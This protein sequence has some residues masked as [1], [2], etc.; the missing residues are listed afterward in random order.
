MQMQIRSHCD[1]PAQEMCD[2]IT[3]K[4]EHW[5]HSFDANVCWMKANHLPQDA[6]WLLY[7][8]KTLAAYL[9]I[10]AV[11]ATVETGVCIPVWGIG[12]VCV[13]KSYLGTGIGKQI[14]MAATEWIHSRGSGLLMCGEHN[15]RFY[16]KCGWNRLSAKL[17]ICGTAV[18]CVAMSCDSMLD[19]YRWLRMD[20]NF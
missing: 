19:S 1:L 20:R 6:H 18:D 15:V 8:E 11:T 2:I 5:N 14:V 16:E 12:N 7:D 13:R 9:Y 4:Q 10:A 3:L 17:E